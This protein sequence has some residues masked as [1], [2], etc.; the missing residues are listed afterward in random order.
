MT[1]QWT[2]DLAVG[3]SVI[4]SQHRELF[5]IFNR[6]LQACH[7]QHGKEQLN[8]LFGYLDRYAVLHFRDEE[9]LMEKYSYPD[10]P[11]HRKE[12]REFTRRLGELRA[13]L[14][15]QGPTVTVLIH[16][17]KALLY[18]LSTHIKQIDVALGKYLATLAE[19]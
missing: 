5:E 18:W 8:E 17:N 19:S 6:F 14:A 16:T 7:Q 10:L 15:K 4:D 13:E 3:N 12:H 11:F 9:Q 2:E 1:L